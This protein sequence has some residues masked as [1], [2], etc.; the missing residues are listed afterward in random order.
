[1]TIIYPRAMIDVPYVS[2][3]FSLSRSLVTA[4][5]GN[6][7]IQ[8]AE[9]YGA[10]WTL[11][12]TTK[13]LKASMF[14]QYEAWWLSLKGGQKRFY[15]YDARRC[16]PWAYLSGLPATRFDGSAFDGTAAINLTTTAGNTLSV[17]NL[18]ANYKFSVG[19]YI[20]WSRAGVL[21]LHKVVEAVTGSGA[22]IALVAVEPRLSIPANADDIVTLVKPKCLM[23]PIAESWSGVKDGALNAISFKAIQVIG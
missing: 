6:G 12:L 1:M 11:S 15:A 2:V 23:A 18:P 7:S 17:K 13:P 20:G 22:G 14:D 10:R 3:D 19:D 9:P 16:M 5:H 8:V 21:S 4:Q